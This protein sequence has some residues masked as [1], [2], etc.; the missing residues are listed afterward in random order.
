M[1]KMIEKYETKKVELQG[2]S[3][4]SAFKLFFGMNVIVSLIFFVLI[5][6]AGVQVISWVGQALGRIIEV[7][8]T[9]PVQYPF[10]A[11]PIVASL[12]AS[13]VFGFFMAMF[14]AISAVLYTL[15]SLLMGG[16]KISIRQKI[17]FPTPFK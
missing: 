15:F 16:V 8:I 12:I 13:L 10:F 4:L 2:I 7:V 5:K 9:L 1:K 11:N 6:L 17:D 3:F 14:M